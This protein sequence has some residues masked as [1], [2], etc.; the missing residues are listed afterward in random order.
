[1]RKLRPYFIEHS[2]AANAYASLVRQRIGE[3]R[4]IRLS[5]YSTL[6]GCMERR[7]APA[8]NTCA[9]VARR[10]EGVRRVHRVVEHEG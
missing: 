5:G 6:Q 1:M 10:Q 7:F 2:I 3:L 9:A 8:M 4:E